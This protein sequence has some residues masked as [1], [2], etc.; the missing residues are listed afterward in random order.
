[1]EYRHTPVM[2]AEALEY[3]KPR[4]GGIFIDC[5]LG[6]GGYTKALLDIVGERGQVIGID[7]DELAVSNA[8]NKFKNYKNLNIVHDNFKN[9]QA[10]VNKFL[11]NQ[12]SF[13]VDGIV[14]DLGLSSAQ[15][16]DG[17]RG[18]SFRMDAPLNMSFGNEEDGLSTFDI[19]NKNREQELSR[20]IWEYGEERY[21]N[22]I[23]HKIVEA[24]KTQSI[25][26]TGK[27]VE[28]IGSAVPANYRH[29]SKIYFATRTFQA[30]R[31]ATNREI[32]NLNKVLPQTITLLK[33]GG[34][35][36]VISYHSLEDR[37]VKKILRLESKNC[38]CPPQ[39]PIC[40]CHHQA[41]FKIITK[42]PL[43]PTT[44]EIK[45]N[46]RARSAKM[47]VAEKI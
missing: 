9:L 11:V 36:V 38:L 47:R 30:L 43:V 29:N 10:I 18:L 37:I 23:A 34:R 27:L 31:I 7:M 45:N 41:N 28:I 13:M 39:A 3:L 42:K 19:V 35:L 21:A 22:R 33:T 46:P 6:G 26:T 12:K 15:L 8:N 24:R 4:R 16:E 2:L 40:N 5:T 1:M 17:H 20:I 25:S 32:D 14:F 44:I